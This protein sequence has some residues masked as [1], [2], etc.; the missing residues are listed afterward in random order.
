[1]NEPLMNRKLAQNIG[2]KKKKKKDEE[3]EVIVSVKCRIKIY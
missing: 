2:D 3:P 1:M